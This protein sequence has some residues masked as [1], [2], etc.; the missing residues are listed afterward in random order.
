M[1]WILVIRR[2]SERATARARSVLPVPGTSSSRT[3]PSASSATV[4]IR[5]GSS[6]PTTARATER[7]RSSH[8]RRPAPVTSTRGSG[9]GGCGCGCEHGASAGAGAGSG[10][11]A[12]AARSASMD[13]WLLC[14]GG[15][16]GLSEAYR[17]GGQRVPRPS[18]PARN[19]VRRI[20]SP[21]RPAQPPSKGH[22][23]VFAVARPHPRPARFDPRPRGGLQDRPAH[24]QDQ[25]EL[26]RV[27]RRDR[28]DPGAAD[29]HRGR[30][31]AGGRRAGRSS[32]GRSTAR[33]PIAS[34]CA[35]SR[36]AP[37]TRP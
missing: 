2:S 7:R 30:A 15:F 21:R 13:R 29:G 37:I 22:A 4:I 32:T 12:P 34:S 36:W 9:P 25:P 14:G 11:G 33:S 26:G 16:A 35:R 8:S 27:R 18:S 10:S 31:P 28:H 17:P 24:E 1:P 6:A 19:P 3:W 23:R 5:S 20:D